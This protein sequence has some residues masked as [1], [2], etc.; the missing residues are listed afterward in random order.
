MRIK[1][2]SLI[3]EYFEFDHAFANNVENEKDD[4]YCLY[5]VYCVLFSSKSIWRY[6]TVCYWICYVD[7]LTNKYD[8]G[9]WG[10]QPV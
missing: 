6:F 1:L 10:H 9:V 2:K 5:I 7:S 4:M 8:V 3:L